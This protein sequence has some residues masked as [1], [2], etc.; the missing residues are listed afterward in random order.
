VQAGTLVLLNSKEPNPVELP[1]IAT[2]EHA[3]LHPAPLVNAPMLPGWMEPPALMTAR[4]ALALRAANQGRAPQQEI[5]ALQMPIPAL[6]RAMRRQMP[7]MSQMMLCAMMEMFVPRM[8]AALGEAAMLAQAAHL[9]MPTHQPFVM[10]AFP[11]QKAIPAM[12]QEAAAAALMTDY[13][14][15]LRVAPARRAMPCLAASLYRQAVTAQPIFNYTFLLT[16]T[17]KTQAATTVMALAEHALTIQPTAL[18]EART[19]L[20]AHLAR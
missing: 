14:A 8:A 12:E 20:T 10:M 1:G 17:C 13:A 19:P 18:W 11:A 9:I 15:F 7:A 6:Q 3:T 16:V 5:P 4:S 2:Q